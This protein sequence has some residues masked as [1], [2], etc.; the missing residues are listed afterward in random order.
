MAV[1]S[2][3]RIPGNSAPPYRID[4]PDAAAVKDLRPAPR[5]ILFRTRQQPLG[6]FGRRVAFAHQDQAGDAQV[7][8]QPGLG[9]VGTE[10]RMGEADRPAVV[11]GNHQPGVVE[12]QLG[13]HELL[14]QVGGNRLQQPR[15]TAA[16]PPD[17]DQG[18][19]IRVVKGAKAQHGD[20]Q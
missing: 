11:L 1:V 12:I 2:E 16:A 20:P 10:A 5:E 14:E 19:R 9:L 4:G 8:T 18:G 13:E 3:L 17:V 7:S 6:H 15:L